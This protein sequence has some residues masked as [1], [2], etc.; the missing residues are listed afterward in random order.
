[1]TDKSFFGYTTQETV[2]HIQRL[3]NH[4][5]Y[6][7]SKELFFIEGVRNFVHAVD[8]GYELEHVLY[9]DTL[10]TSAVA[11][12]LVRQF[13]RLGIAVVDVTPEDFRSVSVTERA[14][15]IGAVVRQKWSDLK[16]ALTA[17]A[18]CW[19]VL[20]H[21]RSEGNF[22]TLIRSSEAFGST[23]FILLGNSVDPFS[24]TSVRVTMGALFQQQFVRSSV[25]AFKQWVEQHNITL[26]GASPDGTIA[27]HEYPYPERTF[28]WLGEEREGLTEEQR[29][30]CKHLVRVP[31]VGQVDSLNVGVAG[32][33]LLYDV[34][35]SRQ[36]QVMNG[37]NNLIY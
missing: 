10:C 11:R 33:L 25:N 15:G 9:S 16:D 12:K 21:I 14:S 20:E 2:K 26:I 24:P 13:R 31:M 23:G 36:R 32:S 34:S 18:F 5:S 22:G 1:M 37:H 3:Q 27:S 8:N 17:P 6:R 29:S 35:R 30:L 28:L 19:I 7:D 4:R